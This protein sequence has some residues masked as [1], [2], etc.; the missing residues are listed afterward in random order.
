MDGSIKTPSLVFKMTKREAEKSFLSQEEIERIEQKV[1][2][3]ERIHNV[4]DIF[5]FSCYTGC[6]VNF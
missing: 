1:F 5:L 6:A 2:S 4:K 3:A